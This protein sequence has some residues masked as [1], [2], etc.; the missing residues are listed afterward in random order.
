LHGMD[1]PVIQF[2]RQHETSILYG[3]IHFSMW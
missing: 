3:L 2:L 1:I